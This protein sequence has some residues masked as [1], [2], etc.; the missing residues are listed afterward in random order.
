M[1][2]WH[3][4]CIPSSRIITRL[5]H[6]AF[7]ATDIFPTLS[8]APGESGVRT[9]RETVPPNMSGG[10]KGFS[11]V[12]RS[13]RGEEGKATTREAQGIRFVNKAD[14]G[15]RVKETRGLN[16]P[17]QPERPQGSSSQGEEK[18]RTATNEDRGDDNTRTGLES[19]TRQHD[20]GDGTQGQGSVQ[21]SSMINVPAPIQTADQVE[22]QTETEQ[23]FIDAE[24]SF[25]TDPQQL[26][27]SPESIESLNPTSEAV[28]DRSLKN[29]LGVASQ[30]SVSQQSNLSASQ[31]HDDG[32]EVQNVE[33]KA[34]EVAKDGDGIGADRSGPPH[35]FK[36]PIPG[37]TH[38]PQDSA[39][40]QVVQTNI[41]ATSL[42]EHMLVVKDE[43]L[44]HDGR[45]VASLDPV[46]ADS[47][48]PVLGHYDAL[49][50]S[51]QQSFSQEQQPGT[52]GSEQL[53][54]LWFGHDERQME[55]SEPKISQ[56]FVMNHSIAHGPG[57]ESAVPGT[58]NPT[59]STPGTPAPTAF[60]TPVQ[61]GARSE[62]MAQSAGTPVMRSVV[63][64][65]N[66]PDLGQVNIRVA[67]TNDL[68]HTHFSSD[69][70]EVGQ[71]FIN[72]QDRLQAALQA[73]GLDMGQFR[74][75]ID[76]QSGGRSFQQSSSQEQG[77]SWNQG[78]H[79]MGRDAH[80]DQQDHTRG[81]R[82]GLL[83]VVA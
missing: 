55:N 1:V 2:V 53:S 82:H 7:I 74:V 4:A 51:T 9:A 49:G 41:R 30:H 27:I 61:S 11:S 63:M 31:V 35:I 38:L 34:G 44:K 20:V 56:A 73:S 3:G 78:S 50:A 67:M 72:G 59:T 15:S 14:D 80:S 21:V 28:G 5:K 24:A 40:P 16:D 8:G 25:D 79:G 6:V 29:S 81:A 54:E 60:V 42:G 36:E 18:T 65:V 75:D 47:H 39:L 32:S 33:Q 19:S 71:F 48:M 58:A 45:A 10:R 69:R 76:R 52:D 17:T 23:G 26:L 70:R 46:Q 22:V 43:V 83:N 37:S 13:V 64:N 57:V 66:Q 12:L 62:E 68:V 77:Q